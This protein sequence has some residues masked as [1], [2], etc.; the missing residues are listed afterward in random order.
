M[1]LTTEQREKCIELMYEL[2]MNKAYPHLRTY[3]EFLSRSLEILQIIPVDVHVAC[4]DAAYERGK[5]EK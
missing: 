5:E 3:F 1:K 4:C 2:E